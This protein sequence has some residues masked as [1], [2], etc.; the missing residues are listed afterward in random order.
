MKGPSTLCIGAQKAGTTWLYR[1]L[2]DRS[3]VWLPPVKELHFFDEKIVSSDRWI[4]HLHGTKAPAARWKR[5]VAAERQ[6]RARNPDLDDR[7][8]ERRAWCSRYFF[9]DP[10]VDWYRSLFPD[11][12]VASLDISPEY[13]LL[14]E[15]GIE[16]VMTTVPDIRVIYLLR[17][18]IEREWSGAQMRF[19]KNPARGL[20]TVLAGSHRHVRYLDTIDRWTAALE[21]D[22]LYLGW[23]DDIATHPAALLADIA[24][25]IGADPNIGSLPPG[26][27]NSGNVTTMPAEFAQALAIDL[28]DEI[29][30]LAQRF[31][32]PAGRWAQLA[33]QLRSSEPSGDV[34]Y[35]LAA[36]AESGSETIA[37]VIL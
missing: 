25:F 29:D 8:L 13:A 31:D 12:A 37:S 34:A 17:N 26:R 15:A 24:R 23:F 22:H 7:E 6:R 21:P 14:D 18:P 9:E 1:C 27:P 33:D 32:G 16:R 2:E 3:D 5:Q 35:P 19:R 10:S 28:H 4:D 11:R 20:E 30:G 36:P